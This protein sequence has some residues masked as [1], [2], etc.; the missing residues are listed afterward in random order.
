MR[1]PPRGTRNPRK[2]NPSPN[3]YLTFSPARIRIMAIFGKEGETTCPEERRKKQPADC[4]KPD[5]DPEES[6]EG[7]RLSHR[8]AC[9]RNGYL[10]LV[11]DI[12]L[13][14]R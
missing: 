3:I 9:R 2:N 4:A 13:A 6:G 14:V 10:R 8:A 1:N 7:T 12:G 11:E 5:A